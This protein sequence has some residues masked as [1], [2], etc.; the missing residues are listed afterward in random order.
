MRVYT[1][2][3]A[4]DCIEP[5]MVDPRAAKRSRIS[6]DGEMP[7][8]L[9]DA[10]EASLAGIGQVDYKRRLHRKGPGPVQPRCLAEEDLVEEADALGENRLARL[11]RPRAA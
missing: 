7:Q 5:P 10:I 2:Q 4:A 8:E 11:D 3:A 1:F 6:H 9:R